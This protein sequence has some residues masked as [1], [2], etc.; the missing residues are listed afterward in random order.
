MKNIKFITFA[1]FVLV[2]F[3][4]KSTQKATETEVSEPE[5]V[6]TSTT[7]TTLEPEP[8]TEK[9]PEPKKIT[10]GE[11]SWIAEQIAP[12]FWPKPLENKSTMFISFHMPVSENVKIDNIEKIFI[13]SPKDMW[14]L[15]GAAI[16]NV[17]EMETKEKKLVIKR[18]QCVNGS[19][20]LGEWTIELSQKDGGFASKV[21]NVSGLQAKNAS[22]TETKKSDSKMETADA[23]NE[24]SEIQYLV[25]KAVEK[26]EVAGLAIPV[27]KS[28]SRDA[29]TIEIRFSV[30]DAR[31]KNGYFWFDV[32]GEVYYKD[33]GSMINATG[34]PVNG[35]RKFSTDGA[36][37]LY[38]LRKDRT[39]SAW[40]S[41][42]I[43]AYFVVADVNRVQS[44]WEERIRSV[45]ERAVVK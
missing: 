43:G 36:E 20:P 11:V 15:E 23:E 26:N 21:V 39:N 7:T 25:P 27:I 37:C 34:N 5:P 2:L 42:I 1:L 44:P 12:S 8:E 29:E 3:S 45:S 33:S 4:C 40:F 30:N 24:A 10:F 41:K 38:I 17:V 35:C 18:L 32:P 22:Q 9:E 19:V 6:Q 16:K 31:V 14:L 28:V 13:V